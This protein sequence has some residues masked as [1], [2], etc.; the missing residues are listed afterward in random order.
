MIFFMGILQSCPVLCLL[1]TFQELGIPFR[2]LGISEMNPAY[3]NFCKVNHLFEH[4]HATME[5]Q[6]C[7]APCLLH[8]GVDHCSV[9][10]GAGGEFQSP[11]FACFGT[12]CPPFSPQRPKRFHSGSV[13]EHH[14]YMTTFQGAVSFMKRF[15]P[16]IAIMEQVEGFDQRFSSDED[17]TPK[18]RPGER[19]NIDVFD[20]SSKGCVLLQCS[21]L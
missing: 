3:Q 19:C 17:E 11:T 4:L 13:Q 9:A 12:P 21:F 18:T 20:F 10:S 15:E 16:K 8:S 6:T 14:A 1:C 2:A 5:E 7:D